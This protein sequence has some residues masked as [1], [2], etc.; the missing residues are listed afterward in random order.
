MRRF[1]VQLL[2]CIERVAHLS[3]VWPIPEKRAVFAAKMTPEERVLL[4]FF[5]PTDET[6][7]AMIDTAM[8]R[9]VQR[10]YV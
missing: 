2:D 6:F 7:D 9:Y 1:P 5:C 3:M 8:L 10:A 4:A